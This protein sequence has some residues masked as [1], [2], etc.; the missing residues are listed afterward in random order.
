MTDKK[1]YSALQQNYKLFKYKLYKVYLE[2]FQIPS[3]FINGTAA[4]KKG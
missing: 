1:I 3:Y 4:L 2:N